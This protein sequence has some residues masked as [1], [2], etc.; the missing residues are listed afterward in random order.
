MSERRWQR[1][2]PNGE[3]PFWVYFDIADELDGGLSLDDLDQAAVERAY[4]YSR[5]WQLPWPARLAEAE[6]AL[7]T[8][9]LY[10]Y[11]QRE[12]RKAHAAPT[13]RRTARA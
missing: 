11:T 10:E 1:P 2:S 8:M 13:Q 5:A 4:E 7:N 12:M 9:N 3:D 6:E